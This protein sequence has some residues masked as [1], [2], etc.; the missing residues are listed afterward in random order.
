MKS[1]AVAA[2]NLMAANTVSANQ[3]RQLM[4]EIKSAIEIWNA[5]A[6]IPGI[7]E[8]ARAEKNHPALDV[9]TEFVNMVSAAEGVITQIVADIPKASTGEVAVETWGA[10]GSISVHQFTPTQ[11]VNLRAR[12]DALIAA[13]G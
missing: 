3:I 9:V 8:Y 6:A 11:T 1:L 5:T 7:V 12:L 2:N 4:S 10:D 13:I